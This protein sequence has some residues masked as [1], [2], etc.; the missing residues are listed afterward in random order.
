[1]Y[2]RV[3]GT[4]NSPR[5]AVKVVESIRDG[6][7]V[8]QL[9]VKHIGIASDES[10][11]EKLKQL[12]QEFIAQEQ[13]RREN[14]TGQLPLFGDETAKER[15][16]AIQ[17][18]PEKKRGRKPLT[19][20][21]DLT[22]NDTVI[23]KNLV[24]E[25]RVIDGLHDIGGHVFSQLGYDTILSGKKDIELLR[26]IVLMRIA[27]PGSKFKAQR[28]LA[29]R[30]ARTHD[31]DAIYRMMDKLFPKIG[32]IK[33][34]TFQRAQELIP[35][36][37]DI[38]FFDCTTLYFESTETDDL[39]RFGYSK[40]HRFNTTQ[41]VLAMATNSDG[42]PLGYELFEGNKAEVGTLLACLDSWKKQFNIGSVCFVAD[43]AM[44]S[45]TNL[46]A[47]D[48]QGYH[49]VVAAK[50]RSMSD[51]LKSEILSER[52][53]N[54]TQLGDELAWTGE[55]SYKKRR[56]IVSYK[57]ARAKRDAI[58]RQQVLNKINKTLGSEGNTQ[59]L[60]TNQGVK[61]YTKTEASKTVLDEL[62][63]AGDM[64][65]DGL[66]GVITNIKDASHA[67]II[68]RYARLWKI[69]ESFR[70]NKHTLSMRPIFHF[71]T[72]RIHAH[73]ALC[74]MAF[75]VVRHMEYLVNLTQKISPQFILEE[76]M[77]VQSSILK[78]TETGKQYRMPGRFSQIASK[79]YK[80]FNISRD[81]QIKAILTK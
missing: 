53:Y 9:I 47:L 24:E 4:P 13:L 39:R 76:L 31:L 65:W 15:L 17:N 3:T 42:L 6:F 81:R 64:A 45:E 8:R 44:M 36:S 56:L 60:I 75:S 80:A 79:I 63:I 28:L 78:D 49:Y 21:E 67:T 54:A 35:Q 73:I 57:K 46:A 55:F 74:Y 27:E 16:E 7:T 20:L 10:E 51:E 32:E 41:V 48:A 38:L 12:G 2:I 33:A 23:I 26:D 43:R 40:D 61:K 5:R 58:Q 50:L 18:Q 11:I 14:A 71:K 72:E 62:K 37:I 30:F 52:N 22:E 19:K 34:K 1:M 69:E 68:S 66:H 25:Q 59:K 77:E 70:L 29:N